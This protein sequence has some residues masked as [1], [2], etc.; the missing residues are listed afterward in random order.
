MNMSIGHVLGKVRYSPRANPH[1]LFV[2]HES[3]LAHQR[4]DI[5]TKRVVSRS[6][7]LHPLLTSTVTHQSMSI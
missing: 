7:N 3:I 5:C 2:V 6:S 1:V 4:L